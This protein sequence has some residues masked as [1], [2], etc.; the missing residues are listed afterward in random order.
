MSFRVVISNRPPFMRARKYD[1]SMVELTA[2]IKGE[3][4][5]SKIGI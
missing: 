5:W 3:G 1:R 2:K 4:N